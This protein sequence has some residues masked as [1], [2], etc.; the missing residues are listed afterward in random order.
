LP[1]QRRDIILLYYFLGLNDREIAELLNVLYRTI[2][3][4]RTSSLKKMRKIMEGFID[5]E[6]ER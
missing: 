5:E 2:S 4:Q 1:E 3:Y 6:D